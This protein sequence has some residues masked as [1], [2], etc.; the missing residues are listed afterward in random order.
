MKTRAR[1]LSV[2][3]AAVMVIGSAIP[4]FAAP[5]AD[6]YHVELD[7]VGSFSKEGIDTY[8]NIFLEEV[9]DNE[10][11]VYDMN[12]K[13]IFT[14]TVMSVSYNDYLGRGMYQF[15]KANATDVNNKALVDADGKVLLPFEAAFYTWPGEYDNVTQKRFILAFYGTEETDDTSDY[16]FYTTEDMFAMGEP[17]KDDTLYKGYAKIYDIQ[18]NKFVDGLQFEHVNTYDRTISI[19]GNSILV[20]NEDETYTLYNAEGKKLLDLNSDVRTT[21]NVIIENSETNRGC[22]IY[23]ENGTEIFKSGESIYPMSSSTGNY[24]LYSNYSGSSKYV[25]L[26]EKGNE[27]LT[28]DKNVYEEDCDIFKVK[29]DG[30]Y[31]F[32]DKNGKELG[33]TEGSTYSAGYGRFFLETG[34]NT[35]TLIGPS[36]TLAEEVTKESYFY[37]KDGSI[38]C[39]N[40][41]TGFLTYDENARY[42]VIG[43]LL[44]VSPGYGEAGAVYDLFNG[45][46]LVDD[47]VY[48]I[49][50]LGERIVL[51]YHDGPDYTYKTVD[52]S[53]V[54]GK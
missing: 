13:K 37:T 18:N 48:A 43:Y 27:I 10:N 51:V 11:Y 28:S 40:D 45:K 5:A 15:A 24:L 38:I 16:L 6:E 34:V 52:V 49:E 31:I 46:K 53:V 33:Q 25:V 20:K 17:G 22:R 1:L 39:L 42:T 14:E 35:Y 19:V 44:F 21:D 32:I 41:G 26:D 23:D 2:V 36:G 50:E 47:G 4:A 7:Q 3:L 54:E 12:G 9:S 30:P 8:Y 29:G